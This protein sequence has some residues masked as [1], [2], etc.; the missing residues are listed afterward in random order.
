MTTDSYQIDVKLKE[1]LGK[2][3]FAESYQIQLAQEFVANKNPKDH[4]FKN[5]VEGFLVQLKQNSS[6]LTKQS[7]TKWQIYVVSYGM[8]TGSEING[9]RPSIVYKAPHSTF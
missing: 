7:F 9:D 4:G 1:A 8:N 3:L 6:P 2:E 5:H